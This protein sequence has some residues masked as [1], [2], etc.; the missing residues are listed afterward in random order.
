MENNSIA[1]KL[2]DEVY[3][4]WNTEECRAMNKLDVISHHFTP[5]HRAAVQFGNMNYQVNNGGFT[6]WHDNGYSEDLEDLIEYAKKGTAQGIKHIDALLQI[7]IDIEAL[8]EHN[9]YDDVE[10]CICTECSGHGTIM[11][12]NDNDEEVEIECP[13]CCGEGAWEEKIDGK[14]EYGILLREF[15]DKYYEFN[16][17]EL[18][19]SFD[20]FISR[21]NEEVNIAK[22]KTTTLIKPKC[23]LVGTDGNVFS[24]I[25]KVRDSLR[26]AGLR[27]KADEF[28]SK[29]MKQHS[30]DDVLSLCFEYV[31][32]C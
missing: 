30:Y 14:Q 23:K 18:I 19:A 22:V 15:N 8:G 3:D 12:Y 29:A 26:N 5:L 13:E 11:D 2:M 6:Q 9:D 25:G 24:I 28:S 7:L 1:Q 21:F 31:E 10:E 16:E 32:V 17:D 27:D 4:K 20:E